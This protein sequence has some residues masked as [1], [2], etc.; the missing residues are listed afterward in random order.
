MKWWVE[1]RF[2][3]SLSLWILILESELKERTIFSEFFF[4]DLD[5]KGKSREN[6]SWAALTDVT[7]VRDA[8]CVTEFPLSLGKAI[9]C[10]SVLQA[11]STIFQP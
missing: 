6:K 11:S 2:L 5:Q 4:K 9:I 10:L 8:V 7:E 1:F 3:F